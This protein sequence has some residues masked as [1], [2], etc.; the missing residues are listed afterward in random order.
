MTRHHISHFIRYAALLLLV[1]GG[2]CCCPHEN[3]PYPADET[4]LAALGWTY[5]GDQWM[6]GEQR[7]RYYCVASIERDG[8]EY[9]LK[10]CHGT[11]WDDARPCPDWRS[12]HDLYIKVTQ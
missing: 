3:S 5:L 10:I 8:D 1:F 2:C 9:E 12:A 11:K 6:R 7:P 4:G